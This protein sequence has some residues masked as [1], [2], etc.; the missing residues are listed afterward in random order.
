MYRYQ[1]LIDATT[2]ATS[3]CQ[4]Q[5]QNGRVSQG[6]KSDPSPGQVAR[7]GLR[8]LFL[9]VDVTEKRLDDVWDGAGK[10]DADEMGKT[11]KV[12]WLRDASCPNPRHSC[13]QLLMTSRA[14]PAP[15]LH[16]ST[17]HGHPSRWAIGGPGGIE[18]EHFKQMFPPLSRGSLTSMA[19]RSQVCRSTSR[20]LRQR[21]PGN[22][23][24]TYLIIQT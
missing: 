19:P 3:R 13:G 15:P 5:G 8:Y 4:Y 17:P 7:I 10:T 12:L 18:S 24:S 22:R 9:G 16:P 1:L 2:M 14:V 23:I 21:N 6:E 11:P 20:R